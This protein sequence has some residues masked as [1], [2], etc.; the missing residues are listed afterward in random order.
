VSARTAS[1][2]RFLLAPASPPPP[3]CKV[4]SLPSPSPAA[5]FRR[6]AGR[7]IAGH[8]DPPAQSSAPMTRL[9]LILAAFP[10]GYLAAG[11]LRDAGW[12]LAATLAAL[13]AAAFC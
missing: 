5:R 8:E 12:S 13:G 1:R 11:V 6:P 2:G 9:L 3:A 7:R 10:A 4:A